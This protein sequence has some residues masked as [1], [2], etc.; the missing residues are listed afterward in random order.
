[1]NLFVLPVDGIYPRRA[2]AAQGEGIGPHHDLSLRSARDREGARRRRGAR[3]GGARA[4]RREQSHRGEAA[5][6]LEMRLLDDGITVSRTADDLVRYHD[7]IHRHRSAH[8]VR[9]RLQLHKRE[10]SKRRSM[11]II[12][13][14]RKLVAEALE[15]FEADAT[16]QAFTSAAPDLVISPINCARAAREADH[17]GEE[18]AAHLRSQRDRWPDAAAA[19]EEGRVRRRHPHH[20]QGRKER[21]RTARGEAARSSTFTCARS[22]ATTRSCSSAARGSARSSSTGAASSGSSCATAS[23]S[24]GSARCSTRTGRRRTRADDEREAA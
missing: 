15:L 3:R 17:E 19:Q 11:G 12:T 8:A 22:C 4:D 16:R 9:V 10:I 24:N 14:K 6:K 23:R 1:M 18:F 5:A 13:R 7:K 20:R 21:Q 2:R